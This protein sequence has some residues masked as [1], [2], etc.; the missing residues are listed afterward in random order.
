MLEV[1]DEYFLDAEEE[2]G[3]CEAWADCSFFLTHSPCAIV[4]KYGQN[5]ELSYLSSDAEVEYFNQYV[6]ANT[7]M[8]HVAIA[9]EFR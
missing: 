5:R 4:V 6:N 7:G 9:Q 8:L 2:P 1:Y 3:V